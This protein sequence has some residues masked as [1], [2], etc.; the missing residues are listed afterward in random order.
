M[1]A[2]SGCFVLTTTQL[3]FLTCRRLADNSERFKSQETRSEWANLDLHG[4]VLK[5]LRA[6][7]GM[8]GRFEECKEA[9]AR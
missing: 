1:I 5:L 9:A 3:I 4:Q 8:L 6:E 2:S 7:T